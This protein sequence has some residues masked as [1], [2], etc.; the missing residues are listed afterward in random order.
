MKMKYDK[1]KCKGR[2]KEMRTGQ[3]EVIFRYKF[4]DGSAVGLRYGVISSNNDIVNHV[5][6]G[7]E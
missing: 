7:V 5:F 4:L 3:N 2:S 6:L 1:L